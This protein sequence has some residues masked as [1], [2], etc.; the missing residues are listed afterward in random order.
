MTAQ[1]KNIRKLIVLGVL[2][3]IA[4]IA[5]LT[6]AVNFS[7]PK[8]FRFSMELRVP[9]LLAMLLA[10]FAIGA[11]SI[12]FQPVINNTIVTPCLLGMNA[13]YTLIHTLVYFAFGSA[14]LLARNTNLSFAVDLVIMGVAATF[15]YGYLFKKTN[16][17]VLYVLLIGTVLSSFF[18]SI[19][20]TM[21]RVMDPNEY[22][23][24]LMNLV[25]SFD[26]VQSEII[27]ACALILAA[28][29]F[30]L[31]KDIALLDVITL[32]KNQAINLGVDYDRTIR[33]LL[34]GV[35]I[36]IAVATAMVGPI[37]FLGLILANLARQLMKTYRH[38]HLMLASAMIGMIVLVAGQ[39]L[40]EHVFAYAVP[41]SV[42]ITIGGGVYFLFLLLRQKR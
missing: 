29:V 5:F 33:R 32:G 22:E 26:N 28:M 36:C 34:I 38:T 25:A 12:V 2:T 19:Q 20:S 14:S 17:N 35:T 1:Q 3:L 16:Y 30:V 23:E 41:V 10:A 9:K 13:L 24:L 27:L 15:I 18:G 31:R 37:S 42:F 6:I 39:C 8:F 11:A 40:V 7:N 4:V 21:V